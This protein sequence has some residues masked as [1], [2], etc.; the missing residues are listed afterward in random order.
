M[1]A[2][3]L[4]KM[5]FLFSI[6][7]SSKRESCWEVGSEFLLCEIGIDEVILLMGFIFLV[8]I[9][10]YRRENLAHVLDCTRLH[11]TMDL[12]VLLKRKCL[13]LQNKDK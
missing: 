7:S 1:G 3:N 5:T 10:S 9:S 6:G 8:Q 12:Q 4:S 11:K 13:T 2:R